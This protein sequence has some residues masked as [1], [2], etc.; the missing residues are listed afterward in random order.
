[1]GITFLNLKKAIKSYVIIFYTEYAVFK[2]AAYICSG[3]F[4]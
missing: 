2:L 3:K 4:L 1:M